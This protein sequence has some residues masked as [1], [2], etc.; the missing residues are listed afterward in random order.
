MR[1]AVTILLSGLLMIGAFIASGVATAAHHHSWKWTAP[2]V[3]ASTATT[4]VPVPA[5]TVPASTTTATVPASTTT[6]TVPASTTTTTVP[7][8]TTTTTVPASTTTLPAVATVPT[9]TSTYPLHTNIVSTTFWVGSVYDASV[10]DGSQDCSTYDA[11]WAYHWSG[12]VN[13]GTDQSI[14][15]KGVI[16]GGCDGVPSGAGS[17]FECAT[18]A[19]TKANG[20]FPTGSNVVPHENPFYLDLPFDDINDP[21]GFAERCAVIPWAGQYPPSDCSNPGFSYMKNHW[22]EITGPNGS[23]CFGQIEDAGPVTGSNYHDANYVFGTMNARPA[24]KGSSGDRTQGDG[25]DVSPALNGCLGFAALNGD[26]DHVSWQFVDA[27]QVPPGPWKIIVTT[28][29]VDEALTSS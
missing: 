15:C 19:R 7:A 1:Q 3:R 16:I 17:T 29:P 9:P 26:D 22:V 20:Y 8:S 24:N 27:G 28:S 5:T 10:T 12:G 4:T 13:V 21:V 25:M 11:E 18:Q 6:T 14:G 2:T 23:T